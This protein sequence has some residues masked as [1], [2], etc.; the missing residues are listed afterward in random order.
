MCGS[1]MKACPNGAIKPEGTPD[2]KMTIDRALCKKCFACAGECCTKALSKA[3]AEWTVLAQ[4]GFRRGA[5]F[6]AQRAALE[7]NHNRTVL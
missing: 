7:M 4:L 1:C 5:P 2:G 6:A 3:G